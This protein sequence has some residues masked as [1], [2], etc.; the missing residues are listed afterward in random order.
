MVAF[1]DGWITQWYEYVPGAVNVNWYDAPS[2]SGSEENATD[3]PVSEPIWWAVLSWFDHVTVVPVL[4]V[5]ISGVNAKFL[6]MIM[7][8]PVAGTEVVAPGVDAGL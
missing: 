3:E 8:A 1:M 2:G 7:V 6:I 5:S 4:I